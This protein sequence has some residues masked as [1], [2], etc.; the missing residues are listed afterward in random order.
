MQTN[1]IVEE[2]NRTARLCLEVQDKLMGP[3][4]WTVQSKADAAALLDDLRR[5]RL[6]LDAAIDATAYETRRGETY[7]AND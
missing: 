6:P 1:E 3:R 2:L 4:K 5:A 7:D